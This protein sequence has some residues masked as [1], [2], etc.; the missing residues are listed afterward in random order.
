[1]RSSPLEASMML[2]N[3][4]IKVVE[5]HIDNRPFFFGV[6]TAKHRRSGASANVSALTTSA[7]GSYKTER[8]YD[9]YLY[10]NPRNFSGFIPIQKA[11]T[12]MAS[13]VFAV[14]GDPKAL[15]KSEYRP[16]LSADDLQNEL[17]D[18]IKKSRKRTK[19]T[20]QLRRRRYGHPLEK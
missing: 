14:S 5:A 7:G 2:D 20:P 6:G 18:E 19:S 11:K 12:F 4:D 13:T 9:W 10:F 16:M 17:R 1:M 15:T 8:S 3:P